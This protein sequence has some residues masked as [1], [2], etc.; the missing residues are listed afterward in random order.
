MRKKG[1]LFLATAVMMFTAAHSAQAAS[2]PST[3]E[4]T[5]TTVSSLTPT[6]TSR[7]EEAVRKLAGNE[8]FTFDTVMDMGKT[9]IVE[10]QLNDGAAV[11]QTEY[12]KVNSRVES[13]TLKYKIGSMD[14]VLPDGL[15]NKVLKA[16]ESF[17]NGKKLQFE[18]FWRVHSP[19]QTNEPKD[20]WVFWGAG[21]SSSS[22]YVD[23]ADE[24]SIS[25]NAEYPVGDVNPKLVRR[26]ENAMRNTGGINV[27]VAHASRHKDDKNGSF[28][29]I[30]EDANES[31][32]VKIGAVTGRVLEVSTPQ[33]DWKSDRDFAAAFAMPKYTQTQA[34]VAAAV[35]A[36]RLFNMSLSGY[37]VKIQKNTYTFTREGQAT[38]AGK[39]NKKGVFYELSL[40]PSNGKLQ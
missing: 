1:W 40:V 30:F 31:N 27:D 34:K 38:L 19:Y 12:N 14:K 25:I 16:V 17:D 3:G 39:I 4:T 7:L 36:K 13:T 35:K 9:W 28:Y 24:N 29:W 26:A 18:A 23:I 33:T 15:K 2:V 8:A 6:V 5:V 32:S 11:F 20:Y 37:S 21:D 10:G 22:L